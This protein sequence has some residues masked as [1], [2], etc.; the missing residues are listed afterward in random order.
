MHSE[1]LVKILEYGKTTL[2]KLLQQ[3]CEN[4]NLEFYCEDDPLIFTISSEHFVLDVECDNAQR[5]NVSRCTLIFVNE[6]LNEK[7]SYIQQYLNHFK[8]N[9]LVFFCLLRYLTNLLN[10]SKKSTATDK[11]ACSRYKC[12]CDCLFTGNYCEVQF[13]HAKGYNVF[14]HSSLQYPLEIFFK[15][16]TDVKCTVP[17]DLS[18][19]F[20]Q[21]DY[22]RTVFDYFTKDKASDFIY[23]DGIIKVVNKNVFI[24]NERSPIASFAFMNGCSLKES[25]EFSKILS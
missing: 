13:G 21:E 15:Q 10:K 6:E 20:T 24:S 3:I 16:P 25:I 4:L 8:N 11:M 5:E 19:I 17:D 9:R 23:T 12:I 2:K 18:S 14:T 22:S 1:N 7:H